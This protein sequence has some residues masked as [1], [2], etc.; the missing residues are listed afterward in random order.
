MATYIGNTSNIIDWDHVVTNIDNQ[1]FKFNQ[2]PRGYDEWRARG[3]KEDFIGEQKNSVHSMVS[4]WESADFNF[5]YIY[6]SE[7]FIEVNHPV[8][9]TLGNFLKLTPTFCLISRILPGYGIPTHWDP[10]NNTE[11]LEKQNKVRR[12]SCFIELPSIG[13]VFIIGDHYLYDQP[14]GAIWEWPDYRTPHIGMN[15]GLTPK[16]LLSLIGY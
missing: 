8:V 12:F 16:Y 3:N 7:Y 15:F 14:Q 1:G 10:V 4:R 2:P 13:H 11:E 9:Q 6:L 5:D